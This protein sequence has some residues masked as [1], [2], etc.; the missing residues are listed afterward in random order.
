MALDGQGNLHV[1]WYGS[2][3][4][5]GVDAG[6]DVLDYRVRRPGGTWSRMND[7]VVTGPGGYTVRNAI[8]VTSDGIIHAALRANVRHVYVNAPVSGATNAINW[9]KA[10]PM[11]TVGYYMDMIADRH[12]TLHFVYS[13]RFDSALATG[14]QEL[15]NKPCVLCYDLWYRRSADG[16]KTWSEPYPL[17]VE[18]DTGSD[19]VRIQEGASG[20]IYIDWDEG[21][22]WYNGRGAPAGGRLV[23]SADGGLT[24]SNTIKLNGDDRPG[25]RPVQVATTE[26]RDG[27]IMAVWKYSDTDPAIYYQLSTDSGN[28]WTAPKAIPGLVVKTTVLDDYELITDRLGIIH[29]YAVGYLNERQEIPLLYEILYQPV[30]DLWTSIRQISDKNPLAVPGWPRAVV[31]PQNEI[32]L[33]YFAWETISGSG[34]DEVTRRVYYSEL[35]GILQPQPT[36]AFRATETPLPT[37]TVFQDLEPT[38]TPFAKYTGSVDAIAIVSRD[39]YAAQTFLGG[40]LLATAF[41]GVIA[42]V[43]RWRRGG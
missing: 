16:G 37:P 27:S 34:S 1:T 35:P 15:E 23:Y 25:R 18:T 26:L 31:G 21:Y 20:R 3:Q 36:Q 2:R 43:I 4:A 9:G 10:L 7:V 13:G 40:T 19:R 24:W 14:E 11:S 5:E 8:A 28:T 41:C 22:D 6:L 17:S 33:T 12:D 29:L 32:F 39:T 30:T 42:L 38:A